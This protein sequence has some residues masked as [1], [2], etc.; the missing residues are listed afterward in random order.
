MIIMYGYGGLE[1]PDF[2]DGHF[3][4]GN[5]IDAEI[6]QLAQIPGRVHNINNHK[7]SGGT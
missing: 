3:Q 7:S 6:P 2:I 5:R 1:R 4:S